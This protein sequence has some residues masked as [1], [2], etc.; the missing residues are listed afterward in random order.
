MMTTADSTTPRYNCQSQKKM[1]TASLREQSNVL[2]F[3]MSCHLFMDSYVIICWLILHCSLDTVGQETEDGAGP[4]KHGEPTKH[5]RA[6][7]RSDHPMYGYRDKCTTFKAN[8]TS[9]RYLLAEFDPLRG[10]GGRSQGVGS[11]AGQDLSSLPT[12]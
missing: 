6:G 5:L 2:V 3:F 7:D 10:G 4:Q 12:G 1:T 9:C 11:V 8:R